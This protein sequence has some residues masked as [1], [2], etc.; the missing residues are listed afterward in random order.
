MIVDGTDKKA[1]KPSVWQTLRACAATGSAGGKVIVLRQGDSP[2]LQKVLLYALDPYRTWGMAE[3]KVSE[4]RGK[5][6]ALVFAPA[7]G[8]DELFGLLD[9][10]SER[11]LTGN[12]AVQALAQQLS[13]LPADIG[14]VAIRVLLKDLSCGVQAKT[15]NTAFPGLIPEYKVGL[16]STIVMSKVKYPAIGEY[17]LDGKRILADV[18]PEGTVLRSRNGI[19]ES[20]YA[21]I[22]VACDRLWDPDLMPSD[23]LVLDGELMWGM[24]GDRKLAEAEAVFVVFDLLPKSEFGQQVCG[25]LQQQRSH[26]VQDLLR[27]FDGPIQAVKGRQVTSEADLMAF[28]AEALAAGYEGVMVKDPTARYQFK[29]A[30]H[31]MKLKPE[32]TEDLPV[33]GYFEGQGKLD[34]MLGGIEVRRQNGV[35]VRVGGGFDD[36]QRQSL[37]AN[38]ETLVGRVAEVKFQEPT[39]DGSLRFPVFVCWRTDK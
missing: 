21:H 27:D 35:L 14:N 3:A 18:G 34:G 20:A 2:E 26:L 7:E 16:A 9:Q 15:A 17:K 1:E 31:W 10:L 36:G 5:A 29:R 39:P 19:I 33:V 28:Y 25:L 13:R 12:A 30:K 23:G 32:D 38:R 24:F 8:W 11:S 37:W 4:A 22:R 6:A